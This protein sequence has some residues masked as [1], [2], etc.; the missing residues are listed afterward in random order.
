M[1][2]N[3]ADKHLIEQ[4]HA[5]PKIDLH[6]HLEG[7]L[8]LETLVDIAREYQLSLAEYDSDKLRPLVQ[9]MPDEPHTM[10]HF[11]SKF[12]I[13]RRFFQSEA[14]IRRLVAEA[15]EDAALDNVKYLELRFT[16]PALGQ[17]MR[18]AFD[19]VVGWVC[20]SAREAARQ[21]NIQ[22]GLIVS[23]N[24]HE[25]VAAGERVLDAALNHCNHGVV[26][27][28]IAGQE[29]GF[30]SRPFSKLFKKARAAGLGITVHAGEWTGAPTVR[31]AVELLGAQRIG[32]GVR[33]GEDPTLIE[34][35]VQRG[36]VL[37]VCPVSNV[38][39]G[40]FSRI[41]THTLPAL[42]RK[43]VLTTINTDD[44]LV[45]N[46]TMTYEIVSL[47]RDTPMQLEDVKRCIVNA[48]QSAFLPDSEREAL[49]KQFENALKD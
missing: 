27:L 32:H 6:R 47:L 20:E 46:T 19:D 25:S 22:I 49:V 37:E 30:S 42:Y 2:G 21:F 16:P 44:P 15:I 33:A 28:D 17:M 36:I 41:K 31:D 26:G 1:R 38:R 12:H 8:R 35:L 43:G 10:E 39:S 4:I 5:L 9:V 11:L 45:A 34:M 24:R 29:A 23:M 18:A 48:A 7:S 14:V 13:L 3:Q 40:V